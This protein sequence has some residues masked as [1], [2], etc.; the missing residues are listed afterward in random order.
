ME[1]SVEILDIAYLLQK[2]FAAITGGL[3]RDGYPLLIF[4]DV[5]I[6]CTS[7]DSKDFLKLIEYLCGIAKSLW[8]ID[9]LTVIVDR[10]TSKWQQ[11]KSVFLKLKGVDSFHIHKLI[12]L[13]P[14]GFFQKHF[15][16]E[17]KD[18]QDLL[19]G[20]IIFLEGQDSLFNHIDVR[21]IPEDLGGVFE[22]NHVDW[23]E[24]RTA[25]ERFEI[26]CRKTRTRLDQV[27]DKFNRIEPLSS[28]QEIEEIR[29]LHQKVVD[30]IDDD[31]K[32]SK[33]IAET[34]ESIV[35]KP[36]S[37]K[38]A[39][40]LTKFNY[41][42]LEKW[43]SSLDA[44]REELQS[45]WGK[46]EKYLND[47]LVLCRFEKEFCDVSKAMIE[48]SVV[49]RDR[50]VIGMD[51]EAAKDLMQE[52]LSFKEKT[53]GT[54][55]KIKRLRNEGF[56]MIDSGHFSASSI[57]LR[58]NEIKKLCDEFED[59]LEKRQ[60]VVQT[61]I[62]VHSCLDQLN[63]WCKKGVDLLASQSLDEIQHAEGAVKALE[64]IERFIANGEGLSMGK[65]NRLNKLSSKLSYSDIDVKVK[66]A[67]ARTEEI[68]EMFEKRE[69]S[70]KKLSKPPARPVQP[71][72]AIQKLASPAHKQEK[73]KT[74]T[75]STSRERKESKDLKKNID[76]VVTSQPIRK[77]MSF[78]RSTTRRRPF[79]TPAMLDSHSSTDY[80]EEDQELVKKTK[81]VMQEIVETERDYVSDI[82]CVIEGYYNA[83]DDPDFNIPVHLRGKKNI[84]FG[85]IE[86]IYRFHKTVFLKE[87]EACLSSPYL[88]GQ[89]FLDKRDE[90]QFYAIYCK[91]KPN[92][93]ALT[94]EL[95][96]K[97]TFLK[98]FQRKLGHKL[99]L[100]SYLLKPVQRITKYQ[101]L[102][103]EMMKYTSRK[104][105][106]LVD[107]QDA[108]KTVKRIVR[109]VNDVMH[110]TG[111]VGCPEDVGIFGKLIFQDAFTVWNV[112]NSMLKQ[113]TKLRGKNRQV[114]LYEKAII[115]TR[116]EM[117]EFSEGKEEVVYQFKSL[118]K[119]C[120][121]GLTEKVK[122]NPCKFEVW[123]QGRNEVYV[124]QAG[125]KETKDSWVA[126]I[127]KLL[128]EQ[129]N[130]VK[131]PQRR[132][133]APDITA[134]PFSAP[135]SSN[136][137]NG[138]SSFP[139]DEKSKLPQIEKNL[140]TPK[141]DQRRGSDM[142]LWRS[143]GSTSGVYLSPATASEF[144]D[145]DTGSCWS[146]SEFDDDFEDENVYGDQ[147]R[148]SQSTNFSNNSDSFIRRKFSSVADYEAVEA[149]EL[150][151]NEGDSLEYVQPGIDGWWYMK[152]LRT[153]KEG[154]APSSY[155]EEQSLDS[156]ILLEDQKSLGDRKSVVSPRLRVETTV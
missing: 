98:D 119:M 106:A 77:R 135:P 118:F 7:V 62:D 96:V 38:E 138:S 80:E 146:D 144:L 116:K 133:S 39:G 141:L 23:V 94:K 156:G 81:L 1:G 44:M 58:C 42:Y 149:T 49:V 143:G 99:P 124:L 59:A 6:D 103:Q 129:L 45:L 48:L 21:Q 70:L 130:S 85:N 55:E 126:E 152:N 20:K 57:R 32:C 93:D 113:I 14:N 78:R 147:D 3:D 84:I 68:T 134:L 88:V 72:K 40:P 46:H 22:F 51:L 53:K 15:N 123:L 63:S 67:L 27:K 131:D 90:F 120:D 16:S 8:E 102:L 19:D 30:D 61:N 65:I 104:N 155:V 31:F 43:V 4:Y 140:N 10:R 83:F 75:S 92:S 35:K 37:I 13:K 87:L 71:V 73:A 105:P 50:T 47:S 148:M 41:D 69:N 114:F 54:Y 125:T 60:D 33:E 2:K 86:G 151:F 154:W 64:Q 142:A 26:T 11:I 109:N 52:L 145:S 89:V 95:E 122:E 108:I 79:S 128:V 34:L 12:V 82:E 110:S 121:L 136:N 150:S 115:I 137:N 24:H 117:Q 111:L 28:Q 29:G 97:S 153:G 101:L 17:K 5:G 76:V 112:Q 91:N 25:I 100:A 56:D 9:Y 36:F 66:E 127:R 74:Q 107:L 18:L 139:F 132:G